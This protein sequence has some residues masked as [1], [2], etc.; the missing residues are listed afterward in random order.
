MAASIDCAGIL[1]LRNADIELK[2]GEM[3]IGRKNTRVRV[4]F[5]VAMP[6]PD[7]RLLWLQTTS[8]AVECSQRSG[9]EVPQVESFSPSCCSADG[10]E[11]LLI[12]GANVSLQSRVVFMEK[13]PDGRSL[14][15]TDARVVSERSSGGSLVVEVPPLN[16]RTSEP[17]QVQFCVSNG[18]RRRS[19]TQSFTFLPAVKQE[20]DHNS[21]NAPG[22]PFH[23]PVPDMQYYE[24]C[25]L[26][27]HCGPPRLHHPPHTSL[28]LPNSSSLPP[29]SSSSLPNTSCLP[30]NSSLPPYTSSV[31][32]H[33][34]YLPPNT[35]PIPPY[36][37]S[38]H[39]TSSLPPHPSSILP[40]SSPLPPQ[41]SSLRPNSIPPHSSSSTSSIPH[42]N[43]SILPQIPSNS[44]RTSSIP[45]IPPQTSSMPPS[46]S[47]LLSQI[48]PN[49][50]QTFNL[51]PPASSS[52]GP[53]RRPSPSLSSRRV[54]VTSPPPLKVSAPPPSI[55]Q[56]REERPDSLG[57]QEIT[58]DDGKE[59]LE[60]IK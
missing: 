33:S 21:H 45:L 57:L 31:P 34:S 58:L 59:L 20:P 12:T 32:L 60:F 36:T 22:P 9:Q 3:D 54:L 10:G 11:E 39:H 29:Y 48:P 15:E 5:R 2:K 41:T 49:C 16:R 46:T 28:M 38:I 40:N 25:D 18:K 42:Q 55:K 19:L 37:S 30:P 44:P 24:S 50:P 43:S 4:V 13:G 52:G 7:G 26:P 17:V 23:Q 6:Q 1:K 51:P 14:W 56:E 35:S 27:V 47:S 8:N 53:Q